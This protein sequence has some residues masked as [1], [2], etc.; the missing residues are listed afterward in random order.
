M[1]V[2]NVIE[3]EAIEGP[4]TVDFAENSWTR[5]AT[6]TASSPQDRDGIVWT[7]GGDDAA[8]FSIDRPSGALRFDLDAVAPVIFSKPPDFEAPVGSGADNIYE[9]T[10]LP[11][12]GATVADAPVSVTVTVSDVDE[13]VSRHSE[14]WVR[15][16]PKWAAF[17]ATLG[18]FGAE[19]NARGGR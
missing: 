10:L 19:I 13:V 9:V 15:E 6:F 3:L 2:E 8:R 11:G 18:C 1:T 5:V 16:M 4:E 17:R 14:T 7:L 12:V